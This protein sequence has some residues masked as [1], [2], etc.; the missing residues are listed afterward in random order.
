MNSKFSWVVV[1]LFIGSILTSAPLL[2]AQSMN[3]AD[4]RGSVT[5][6]TGA[7]LSF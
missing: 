6:S 2:V 4:L 3:S 1:I 7:H 5:D